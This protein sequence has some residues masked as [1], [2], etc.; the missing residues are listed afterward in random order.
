MGCCF[1]HLL[2]GEYRAVTGDRIGLKLLSGGRASTAFLLGDVVLLRLVFLYTFHTIF[3]FKNI[4]PHW[5]TWME[6]RLF[7]CY[8]LLAGPRQRRVF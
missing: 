6:Y 1:F 7:T 8:F 4:I 5:D 3:I 2:C